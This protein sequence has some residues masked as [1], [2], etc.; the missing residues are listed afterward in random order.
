MATKLT[1]DE[2]RSRTGFT[3]DGEWQERELHLLDE[4]VQRFREAAVFNPWPYPVT[5]QLAKTGIN[6]LRDGKTT[7]LN[8]N[9]LTTWTI[10]HELAH[11][12]D[13][14]TGWGLSRRMR[15]ETCSGFLFPRLHLLRPPWKFFWYH[16]GS[17]PPPCGVD[18]HFNAIEDFA[19]SVTA[20]LYPEEAAKRA[21]E[22]GYSYEQWGYNHFH[23]TPRGKFIRELM[24]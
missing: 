16:V 15:K 6:C 21:V 17:P 12:W 3:L 11:G 22:R 2:L 8:A 14:S 24:E 13:A 19:E 10:A 5:I 1:L 9:S 4:V 7:C 18:K 20:F 23:E